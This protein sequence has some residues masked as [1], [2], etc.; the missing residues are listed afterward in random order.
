MTKQQKRVLPK[1]RAYCRIHY[2]KGRTR[3]IYESKITFLWH[4]YNQS[5]SQKHKE[6]SLKFIESVVRAN[7]K[8][9]LE[10]ILER[11]KPTVI[12]YLIA[13]IK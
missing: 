5:D 11:I 12:E 4:I 10:I 6:E 13:R 7:T 3:L 2:K 1:I 9:I 8:N